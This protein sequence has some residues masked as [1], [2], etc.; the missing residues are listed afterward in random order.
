MTALILFALVLAL[1]CIA[2]ALFVDTFTALIMRLL[3][4]YLERLKP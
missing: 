3:R 1:C 2:F 4:P